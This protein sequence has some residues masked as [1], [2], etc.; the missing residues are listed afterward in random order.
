LEGDLEGLQEWRLRGGIWRVCKMEACLEALLVMDF[1]T[2]PPNFGVEAHM[3][4]PA[5]VAPIHYLVHHTHY[6]FIITNFYYLLS[7]H[8]SHL[9]YLLSPFIIHPIFPSH[10][11]YL[12]SPFIIH[13]ITSITFSLN[14]SFSS[15]PN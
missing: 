7:Y 3:E 14:N 13:F 4:A 8:S 9:S 6:F 1:C 12:L 2:K 5:G 10:L 15:H 11:S